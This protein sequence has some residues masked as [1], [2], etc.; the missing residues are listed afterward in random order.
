MNGKSSRPMAGVIGFIPRDG[1]AARL[2][3]RRRSFSSP[4][5]PAAAAYP[6][7]PLF[8]AKTG[9]IPPSVA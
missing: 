1:R 9:I 6:P 2:L 7:G 3:T 4:A 8:P 5:L